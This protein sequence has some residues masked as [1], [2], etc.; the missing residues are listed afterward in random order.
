MEAIPTSAERG[1]DVS[2]GPTCWAGVP[3]A[4]EDGNF[5]E[6]MPEMEGGVLGTTVD[7]EDE[8]IERF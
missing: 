8:K 7:C 4:D 2:G 1:V 5:K 3:I 6:N